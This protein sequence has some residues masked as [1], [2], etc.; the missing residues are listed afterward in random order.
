MK[1]SPEPPANLPTEAETETG[2]D[3]VAENSRATLAHVLPFGAW[4]FLLPLIDDPW[5]YV[6][7]TVSGILLLAILRPWRWYKPLR[8]RNL[9]L[10][11]LVGVAVFVVWVF[12]ESPWAPDALRYWYERILVLP[13]GKPVAPLSET[14]YAPGV[15]GWALALIRLGGSAFVIAVIEEFFWRGYLYRWMCGSYFLSRD[16]GKYRAGT[17]FLVAVLFGSIHLQ[18]FVGIVAGLAYGWL[19]LRTRD[20][21]ATAVAHVVTNFILGVYVLATDAYTF[22]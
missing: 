7:R 3:P 8:I 17:F 10:A 14:P 18:W 21:W 6:A 12:P 20:V 16:P 19:Y 15:G 11:F 1:D 2:I 5:G 13:P 4:I 9:P 22:W